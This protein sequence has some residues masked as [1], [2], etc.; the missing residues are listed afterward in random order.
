MI[1]TRSN[2]RKADVAKLMQER[3]VVFVLGWLNTW[4]PEG[5]EWVPGYELIAWMKTEG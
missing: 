5:F 4:E 1:V 3:I 2:Y